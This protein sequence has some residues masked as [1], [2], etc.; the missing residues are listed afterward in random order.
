M[1]IEA[2]ADDIQDDDGQT[3]YDCIQQKRTEIVRMLIE[4]GADVDIQD[5]DG[6]YSIDV[7]Q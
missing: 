5:E 1:L 2:G 7:L 6:K 3:D 4:A